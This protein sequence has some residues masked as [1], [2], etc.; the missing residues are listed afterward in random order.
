M[1]KI[2]TIL[3]PEFSLDSD[4][5]ISDPVNVFSYLTNL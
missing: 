5:K 2:Q 1:I 3:W 4:K